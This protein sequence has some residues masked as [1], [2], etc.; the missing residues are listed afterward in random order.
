M[1]TTLPKNYR[2]SFTLEELDIMKGIIADMKEDTSKPADYAR[3]A[4][5]N[6]ANDNGVEIVQASAEV[7]RNCFVSFNRY[8][9]GTRDFDIYIKF[10]GR[11]YNNFF[12]GFVPLS[13]IWDIVPGECTFS[14]NAYI[15]TF[16]AELGIEF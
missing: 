11:N 2:E 14:R 1:K 9:E 13:E 16:K 15:R 3:A 8:G 4:L 6:F 10:I 7:G 5:A 12:E